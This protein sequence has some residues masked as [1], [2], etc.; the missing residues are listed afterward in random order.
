MAVDD[1]PEG[2]RPWAARYILGLA[3]AGVSLDVSSSRQEELITAVEAAEEPAAELFGN[4]DVL[5]AEDAAE[6]A[7]SDAEAMATESA[8]VRDALEFGGVS[9]IFVGLIAAVMVL[10]GGGRV[11][12]TVGRVALVSAIAAAV[13]LGGAASMQFM[14]GR[15]KVAGLLAALAVLAVGV[16]GSQVEWSGRSTVLIGGL[17]AWAAAIGLL[18][19]GVVVLVVA[20]AVPARVPRTTFDDEEWF[21]RFRGVLLAKGT[22]RAV[23]REHE[24]TLREGLS[25]RAFDEYGR[26]DALAL[27][28]V[29]DDPATP[30]RRL[31]WGAA[32]W[33]GF[34]LLHASFLPDSSGFWLVLR[35]VVV[36]GLL[37]L[38][39]RSA[40]RA[41]RARPA[42]SSKTPA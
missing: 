8:G 3:K 30:S 34:A 29:A 19:P 40:L 7:V 18:L 39:I 25:T 42:S 4:P 27:R 41:R 9:L 1:W 22:P 16:G 26:P 14:A 23:V 35:V 20:R 5:A 6:L 10:L 2:D 24:R 15:L 31:W 38:S 37:W 28:L 12:V 36:G 11:D 17:P 33:F 13:V 32:G 21:S